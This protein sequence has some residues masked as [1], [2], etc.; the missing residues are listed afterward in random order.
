MPQPVPWDAG[1]IA[2]LISVVLAIFI[3]IRYR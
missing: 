1:T 3:L 2:M